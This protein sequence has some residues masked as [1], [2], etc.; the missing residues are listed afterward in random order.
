M[1]AEELEGGVT[2]SKVMQVVK[3]KGELE[4]GNRRRGSR[5]ANINDL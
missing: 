1:F 5:N 2:Q 3:L 4:G